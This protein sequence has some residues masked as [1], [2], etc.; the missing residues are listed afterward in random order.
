MPKIIVNPN[1]SLLYKHALSLNKFNVSSTGALIAYSGKKTGRCP[2]D[3]RIVLSECTENIWWGD[4]NKKLDKKLYYYYLNYAHDNLYNNSKYLYILYGYAGWD[5][6]YR[7]KIK[8]VCSNPYHALFMRNMIKPAN[9]K[10]FEPEFTIYNCGHVQLKTADLFKNIPIYDESLNNTLVAI[11]FESNNMII[12]GTEYAGEMKKGILTMMMYKMPLL[13]TLPLHSSANIDKDKNTTIFFGLSGT[14]KTT[15]SADP[16]RKLIGDDEHVWTDFGI[17][18]IEGGCYAK[19]IGL[20]KDKE[21]DIFEAIKYGAVLENIIYDEKTYIVDYNDTSITKNTRCSYP[22]KNIKNAIFPSIGNHPNNII[23]LTCDAFGVLP[24]VAKL[25]PTQ[26]VLFFIS[27]YTSKIPGTE[28]GVIKPIA[29]FSACFGEPFLVWN[30][31]QYGELLK[32]KLEKHNTNIW[33]INTGWIEGEYGKG[34]RIPLKYTRQIIDY[35]HNKKILNTKYETFP[36]HNIEIPTKLQD[37]PDEVL[38]PRLAWK[39]KN[40]YSVS[41]N[42]LKNKFN[43]NFTNKYGIKLFNELTK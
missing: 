37:I 20:D 14:G 33:L 40:E 15:L 21:P 22:L 29:T 11:D 7:V 18:N 38:D 34:K 10:F 28:M 16:N 39:N 31:I 4:V 24:P 3:K 8:V 27:G 35:I 17:F 30:P 26:A 42:N 36:F 2:K 23:L 19:C 6:N 41:L 9:K 43:N 32:D 12:F 25:N 13:N 5:T 1:T